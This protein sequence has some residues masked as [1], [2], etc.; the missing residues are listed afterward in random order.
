MTRYQDGL[1]FEYATRDHRPTKTKPGVNNP[2]STTKPKYLIGD[3]VE[4][5]RTANELV[6]LSAAT[7]GSISVRFAYSVHTHALPALVSGSAAS[8][9]PRW[10]GISRSNGQC[11]PRGWR[12][13]ADSGRC[14][15]I[16]HH[17]PG[18]PRIH[19]N[20]RIRQHLVEHRRQRRYLLPGRPFSLQM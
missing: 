5:R 14:H 1:R 18:D 15:R 17:P 7:R 20:S 9:W 3:I 12:V 19:R 8:L 4:W 2:R 10:A 13:I 6:P 16:H 11:L